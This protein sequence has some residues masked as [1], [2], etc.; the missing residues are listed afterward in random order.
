M[1]HTTTQETPST[2]TTMTVA[3]DTQT[4]CDITFDETNFEHSEGLPTFVHLEDES[5]LG[6]LA[7]GHFTHKM[8]EWLSVWDFPMDGGYCPTCD[9]LAPF[10]MGVVKVLQEQRGW[11]FTYQAEVEELLID[12]KNASK[13]ERPAIHEILIEAEIKP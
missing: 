12:F 4:E 6:L 13:E 7:C 2:M 3:I 8:S 10:H 5:V 1:E 9:Q 11:T